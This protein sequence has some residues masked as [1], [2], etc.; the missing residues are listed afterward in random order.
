M[1]KEQEILSF[2]EEKMFRPILNSPASSERFKT[3]TRG[4]H[5][6]MKQRDAQ[7]MI[8]YF[9]STVVDS[10]AKHASYG[11]II[12]NE[13]FPEFEDVVNEFRLR[14]KEL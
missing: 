3:A 6:R 5:L 8:Q 7:G 9:W 4:L 1:T 11:R 12:Q 13:K 14:F 2:L 10:R